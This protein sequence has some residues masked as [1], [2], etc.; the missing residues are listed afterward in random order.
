MIKHI[1][2]FLASKTISENTLKS[3]RYDLNQFLT[4]ID[5][6]LSD[7]K[8]VLYQKSLN[9]LSASAKKTQVFHCKSILTLFIQ[10]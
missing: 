6:K 9:H 10:S 8:L 2:A 5:H 7:E 3:Y 1:E 4:L